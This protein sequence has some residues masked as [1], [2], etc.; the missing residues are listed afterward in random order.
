[1]TSDAAAAEDSQVFH[2]YTRLNLVLLLGR[3][4]TTLAELLEGIRSVPGAS[5]YYHTHHFIEDHQ[6]LPLQPPND[7]AYWVRDFLGDRR[8]GEKLA[9]IDTVQFTR[10]EDLRTELVKAIE[11][12][13]SRAGREQHSPEGAEFHFAA[14]QTFVL[15]TPYRA[16]SLAEFVDMVERVSVNS[17]YFHIFEARLR[18]NRGAND[19]SEW[20]RHRGHERLAEAI[21]K[22]D[23]YTLSI[24][25]LRRRIVKLAGQYG[26]S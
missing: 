24:E 13:V 2:F 1:M 17:L 16:A 7:F 18:L 21:S 22:L 4:A 26:Q 19:F 15:P 5:I 25:G 3:R 23:P 8:L 20:L 14:C 12:E 9:S 6:F 10:I 11:C